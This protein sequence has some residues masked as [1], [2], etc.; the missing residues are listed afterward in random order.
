MIGLTLTLPPCIHA[1]S[2][3]PLQSLVILKLDVEDQA[4]DGSMIIDS[5]LEDEVRLDNLSRHLTG[6][7]SLVVNMLECDRTRYEAG[8]CNTIRQIADYLPACRLRKL[9]LYGVYASTLHYRDLL[10]KH[11]DTLREFSLDAAAVSQEEEDRVEVLTDIHQT[12]ELN[13]LQLVKLSNNDTEAHFI[14]PLED[15][16]GR[17]AFV[18]SGKKDVQVGLQAFIEDDGHYYKDWFTSIKQRMTRRG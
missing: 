18:W 10:S 1:L 14:K 8:P 17:A 4:E 12:S 2:V 11:R 9:S 3:S 7:K 15:A 5:G 16:H 13:H 6:L